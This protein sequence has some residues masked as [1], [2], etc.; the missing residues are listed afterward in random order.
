MS[1]RQQRRFGTTVQAARAVEDYKQRLMQTALTPEGVEARKQLKREMTH[2]HVSTAERAARTGKLH[3][4]KQHRV[5]ASSKTDATVNSYFK[6]K[7]GDN[8][9]RTC[10]GYRA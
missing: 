5:K 7:F 8:L 6:A 9:P 1:K 3:E 4:D 10:K 2:V